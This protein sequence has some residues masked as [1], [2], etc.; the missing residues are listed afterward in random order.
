[1]GYE[2]VWGIQSLTHHPGLIK[3]LRMYVLHYTSRDN[4][5]VL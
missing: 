4:V 2:R 5:G 1:M 3:L